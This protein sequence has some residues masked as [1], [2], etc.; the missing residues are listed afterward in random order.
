MS[1]PLECSVTIAIGT[2]N[3][4]ALHA[5]LK[6][7]L[8]RPGDLFEQPV[9][10]Y[11]VDMVR[12]DLLIEIQTGGFAPLRRKIPD[13]L[14]RHRVR[15]VVPIARMRTI[16]R[17]SSDGTALSRRRS[18]LVGRVE[19]IFERLVSIP[20]LIAHERFELELLEIAE[21]ELRAVRTTRRTRRWRKDYVVDGR[22]LVDVL[23]RN[24]IR[25]AV[26]LA[27]L[28]PAALSETF[29]TVDV[30]RLASLPRATAQQM[31][32]CLHAA[33]ALERVGKRSNAHVYR[34]TTKMGRPSVAA[35]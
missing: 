35:T 10:G 21:L 8:A 26:D 18:P 11:V 34:R 9:D 33:G 31:V 3:E 24:L 23:E 30:A 28:L 16:Q 5:G 25:D 1:R 27:A 15:L 22:E 12:G 14:E 17:V 13:L 4:G 20:S 29:T 32:Y 6:R 2:L 7:W 19:D